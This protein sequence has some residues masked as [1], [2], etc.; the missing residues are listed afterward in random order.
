MKELLSPRRP[1]LQ[2]IITP[3]GMVWVVAAARTFSDE[4]LRR[5]EDPLPPATRAYLNSQRRFHPNCPIEEMTL[6][7]TLPTGKPTR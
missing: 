7:G 6:D 5:L 3:D 1:K 4:E 2:E